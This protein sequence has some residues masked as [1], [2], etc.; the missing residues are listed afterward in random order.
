MAHGGGYFIGSEGKIVVHRDKFYSDPPE[1]AR[2]PS[3]LGGKHVYH[4]SRHSGN[5]LECIRTLAHGKP[6][7]VAAHQVV[8]QMG[9]VRVAEV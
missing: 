9:V 7:K 6:V 5:F 8:Q 1:I 2:E 4:S 3:P